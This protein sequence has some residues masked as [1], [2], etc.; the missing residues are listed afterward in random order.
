EVGPELDGHA[1]AV[2]E[3]LAHPDLDLALGPGHVRPVRGHTVRPTVGLVE[4]PVPIGGVFREQSGCR[5]RVTA[6]P[7]LPVGLYP[8]FDTARQSILLVAPGEPRHAGRGPDQISLGGR[9][10]LPTAPA[11]SAALT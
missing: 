5:I 1:L 2:D 3:G 8:R 7:S 10:K 11:A 9:W 6:L 4:D